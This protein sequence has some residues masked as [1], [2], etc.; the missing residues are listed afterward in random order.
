MIAWRSTFRWKPGC[1]HDVHETFAEFLTT[2]NRTWAG[3]MR[4]EDRQHAIYVCLGRVLCEKGIVVK[5]LELN[6]GGK[7]LVLIVLA[8]RAQPSE[9]NRLQTGYAF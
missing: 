3:A 2:G 9:S 1:V 6:L 8:N 5:V 4:D 7:R